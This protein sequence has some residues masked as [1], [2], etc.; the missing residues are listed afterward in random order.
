MRKSTAESSRGVF[1]GSERILSIHPIQYTLPVAYLSV[2]T[3][4]RTVLKI[5][6]NSL[7][8]S[9][10]CK[11]L[12]FTNFSIKF[13]NESSVTNDLFTN[14]LTKFR[15]IVAVKKL[16]IALCIWRDFLWHHTFRDTRKS[17]LMISQISLYLRCRPIPLYLWIRW[18]GYSHYFLHS[19]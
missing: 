12:I 4:Y 16:Y 11:M 13:L 19:D 3:S 9:V 8:S 14:N 18:Q 5:W 7:K 15:W 6:G 10:N 17:K 2:T 1:W